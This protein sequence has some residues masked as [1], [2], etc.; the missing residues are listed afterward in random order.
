MYVKLGVTNPQGS[1]CKFR[2]W[3][4]SWDIEGICPG[5]CCMVCFGQRQWVDLPEISHCS[6]D[7]F[8]IAI[9]ADSHWKWGQIQYFW[10][11]PYCNRRGAF[12]AN[13]ITVFVILRVFQLIQIASYLQ[14]TLHVHSSVIYNTW[15]RKLILT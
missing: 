2:C 4:K 13:L 14:G 15:D 10:L 12:G 9:F 7:I 8:W 11:T 1:I 5:K 3:L 6:K